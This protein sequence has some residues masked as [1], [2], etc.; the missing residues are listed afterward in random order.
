M[1]N[2]LP[3]IGGGAVGRGWFC[4]LLCSGPVHLFWAGHQAVVFFF[5]LSGFVLSLPFYKEN[6]GVA[7]FVIKRICRICIPYWVAAL[8]AFVAFACFSRGGIP[9]LSVWLA[10]TWCEPITA[11]VVAQHA[12]LIGSFHNGC[13]NP[14]LWSLV[15]EMRISLILP[16]LM[17]CVNRLRWQASLFGVGIACY[18]LGRA[19]QWYFS[20]VVEASSDYW[21][22]LMYVYMFIAGALL[23]K[24][25]TAIGKRWRVISPARRRAVFAIALIA[26]AYAFWLPVRV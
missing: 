17:L 9:E 18:V 19:A 15:I 22:T 13:Y 7:A 25:A 12:L 16:L 21:S 10:G 8:I 4:G 2:V 11:K 14:A 26:Y 3:E 1:L 24:H 20:H 6:P 5:V 23:A